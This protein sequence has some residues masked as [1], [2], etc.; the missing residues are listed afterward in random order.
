[1]TTGFLHPGAMGASLAAVCRGDR[2]WCS[3]GRSGA[4]RTRAHAA[5]MQ[6]VGSLSELIARADVI[7]SVCP[8]DAA[9]EVAEAVSSAGFD[10]TYVDVNA[11]APAT[12]RLIGA[13]FKNFVDGG[14]VGPPVRAAGSTRLY[15]SGDLA[16]EVAAL[17]NDTWLDTRVVDGG[18]GAA[19]A[20]KV[21]FAA[22]T[23]G[24]AALLLA[25]RALA[26]AENVEDA[27]LAEW[28]TSLP[29]LDTQATRA[30][31]GNAPKAWR[32]SGEL[33]E[34]AKAFAAHDL[35]EGFA[36]AASEVYQRLA[37]FKDVSGATL[38]DVISALRTPA[39]GRT[40]TA[41]A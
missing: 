18:A 11:I 17:W 1:M 40:P 38:Q 32:F 25:I 20:V 22:W 3:D 26:V 23:K 9:V 12:A 15:L 35:P 14:V 16:H 10:G 7:I 39:D 41:P 33:D 31:T 13:R 5:G 6:E 4:T 29:D 19:S 34:I 30:A 21:C 27:L 8:P 36:T 2:L 24:T 37:Q 28:A